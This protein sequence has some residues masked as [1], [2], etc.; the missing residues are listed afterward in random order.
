M[1]ASPTC[2]HCGQ[3]LPRD[4]AD[5][6]CCAGC[7]IVASML[8]DEHLERYYALRGPKGDPI[9]PHESRDRKWL[10]P[11]ESRVREEKG[12]SRVELDVQGLSCAACVWLIEQLF[13]REEGAARV[14][15]NPALGK[16]SMTVEG[17]FPLRRFVERVESCGY[18]LGP[19]LKGSERA[20]NGLLF[21]MGICI[22]IAMNGM[23]LAISLYAG[24]H[25]GP[26][27]RLF[28]A[29]SFALSAISVAVGGSWFFK[30]AWTALR[31]GILHLDLPIALGIAL[32]FSSSTWGWLAHGSTGYFDTLNVFVAL[33]LVGR[34]LQQRVIE[35]NRLRLLQSDG[36]EGLLARRL[37]PSGP[38]LVRCTELRE[39][40]AI[41]VA[42]GDVVP[43]E[44]TLH[45]TAAAA[46]SLDWIN[47]ESQPRAFAAGST[48]PAGAFLADA[49]TVTVRA[50]QS[51][52]DSALVD[53]LRAASPDQTSATR[54]WRT[55]AQI[56]VAAV[57]VL[58]AGA[59]IVGLRM[60]HDP[61]LALERVT[62]VLIV[63]CPCAFGI[64]APL[65]YEIVQARL[66]RVGL[67]VRSPAFLDRAPDLSKVVFDKTGTLTTGKLRL[68]GKIP[69]LDPVAR[70][71]LVN[72]AMRS[73]HP[74]SSAIARAL[75]GAG[76]QADLVVRE[77]PGKGLELTLDDRTFRLGA[78]SWVGAPFSR[79]EGD[80]A[81][82]DQR[83]L[84]ASFTTVE[85]LRTDAAVEV[86]ALREMGLE[87][88]VLSG[89]STARVH[90][91]AEKVG[92]P[93]D[94]A[95]GERTPHGKAD[96]LRTADH[97]DTLFVGDG[98]N[99]GPAFDLA[100]ASGTP[101]IDRPFLASRADFYLVTAGLRP[102]REALL[103]AR[104]LR[105]V[106]HVTLGVALAYNVVTVAL[107]YAGFMTPLL[108]AV[109]MPLSS[110]STVLAVIV[111]LSRDDHSAFT[112]SPETV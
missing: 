16:L 66:R 58:A 110:L 62:A 1:D 6:Y 13:D 28:H 40:D 108:C 96:W 32:A 21:R 94:H 85:D 9:T 29:L 61:R 69:S 65:A 70:K 86:S 4:A 46:F 97:G 81:F 15:V 93:S 41:L 100:T 23:L 87:I 68:E 92:I 90:A 80:V 3:P 102:I 109:L 77:E 42:H 67:F 12:L 27:A 31:R 104:R 84:L 103:A 22:A 74:K 51:F 14:I 8:R 79:E 82:A 53:L 24:L 60:A 18:L 30:S 91:L 5:L 72:L 34:F 88:F 105:A 11:I 56:Y 55:F 73:A 112:A 83:G 25:D 49:R 95:F 2:A 45:E 50:K 36:A 19:A 48:V 98:I 71:A 10:E 47:G 57:L 89:D 63:T 52:A 7:R 38:S 35:A 111:S 39:G 44:S 99:D 106:L 59:M 26:L 17:S 20:S 33:M 37:D 107:A 101:A 78:P 75:D 64:A 54:W 43:V 76:F